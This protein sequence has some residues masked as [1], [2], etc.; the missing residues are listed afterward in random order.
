MGAKFTNLRESKSKT[1]GIIE[2]IKNAEHVKVLDNTGEWWQVETQSGHKGY[3]FWT[4]I[5]SGAVNR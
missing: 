4:R 5:K 3:V 1:S 2:Q